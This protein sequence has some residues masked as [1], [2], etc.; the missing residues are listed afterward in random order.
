[1]FASSSTDETIEGKLNLDMSNWVLY[2]SLSFN[3]L[4]SNNKCCKSIILPDLSNVTLNGTTALQYMFRGATSLENIHIPVIKD[5]SKV[6]TLGHMFNGCKKLKTITGLEHLS[7]AG[8]KLGS[9]VNKNLDIVKRAYLEGHYIA[10]HG[11]SHSY[12]KIYIM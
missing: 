9:N 10:N 5:A 1:M 6:N 7:E 4:F 2:S 11:Y 3:S 8:M 12:K